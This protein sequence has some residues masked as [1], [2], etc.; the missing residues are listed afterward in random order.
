[1]D[2]GGKEER[3]LLKKGY[4]KGSEMERLLGGGIT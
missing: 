3:W 2:C 1:M 4:G